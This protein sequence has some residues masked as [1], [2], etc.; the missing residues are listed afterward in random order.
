MEIERK[1][2]KIIK[3]ST[4]IFISGHK[5]LD[6]DAI[7][8][9]VGVSSICNHFKKDNY[10]IVDDETHELGVSK[11]LE[12]IKDTK[13][14]I[15]SDDIPSYYKEGST[16]IIV[17]VSKAHLL[18]NDKILHYFNNIIILDHHQVTEQTINTTSI[19]DESYSSAGEIVATLIELYGVTPTKEEATI[20]LSGIVLDT[21][22]FTVKTSSNTYYAAYYLSKFGADSKKIKYYLK[23]DLNDYIIRNK[24]I[25]NVEIINDHYAVAKAPKDKKYKR[26]DL[27]KMADT[28]LKFNNIDASFIIGERI[29]DGIGISARSEGKVDVGSITSELGG[30]GDLN[31]AACQILDMDLDEVYKELK[32]ILT[33]ED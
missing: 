30:G 16:L 17:D 29:D 7:G 33:K 27:A 14:V 15:K 18:Q 6:L 28:L 12:E 23:E 19:I 21:N 1:I 2:K 8:S 5:N 9:C 4:N 24:V 22:N 3:K 13:R 32:N 11:I 25:M 31:T 26:E 20:L 10:I